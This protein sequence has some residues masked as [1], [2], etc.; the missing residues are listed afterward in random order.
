MNQLLDTHAL[1]KNGRAVTMD[2][3]GSHLKRKHEDFIL[4]FLT[5]KPE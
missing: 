2:E 3:Y 1:L 5:P 4:K